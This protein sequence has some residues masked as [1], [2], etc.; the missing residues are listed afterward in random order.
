LV[1][2]VLGSCAIDDRVLTNDGTGAAGASSTGTG[3]SIGAGGIVGAGGNGNASGGS[4]GSTTGGGGS[5]GRAGGAGSAGTGGGSGGGGG[6]VDAGA[7]NPLL[8]DD[9]EDGDG[10]LVPVGGRTGGWYTFND[11]TD[12]G[13]QMPP[14]KSTFR[15][16][17]PGFNSKYAAHTTGSGFAQFGASLS[18]GFESGVPPPFYSV[19]AYKGISFY[20]KSDKGTLPV[21]VQFVDVNTNPDGKV[22]TTMCYDNFSKSIMV[23]NEWA[24]YL[25]L[26][27]DLKQTGFGVPQ[28][29]MLATSAVSNVTFG[30][31]ANTTFDFWIDNLYFVQ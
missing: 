6:K 19:A 21:V 14:P 28:T 1:V 18:F 13:V 22:C 11:G 7:I 9:F 24:F 27:S 23:T 29:G 26:F 30:I 4:A 10:T 20:A 12:G 31:G 17:M 15:P 25:V 3:G 5:A 16:A 8:I 2:A